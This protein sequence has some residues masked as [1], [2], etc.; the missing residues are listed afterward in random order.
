MCTI[1]TQTHNVFNIIDCF[2]YCI[3]TYIHY[4]CWFVHYNLYCLI[5][6][7][8][9]SEYETKALKTLPNIYFYHLF[10]P[11]SQRKPLANKSVFWH[12]PCEQV[13]N[14]NEVW[15]VNV[16]LEHTYLQRNRMLPVIVA[17]STCHSAHYDVIEIHIWG[18]LPFCKED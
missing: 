13:G 14:P 3:I 10:W 18:Y 11:H 7:I 8:K 16:S 6:I 9:C 1:H 2:L 15:N 5:H 17:M 12:Q 4:K